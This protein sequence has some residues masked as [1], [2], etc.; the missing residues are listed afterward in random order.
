VRLDDGST[1]ICTVDEGELERIGAPTPPWLPLSLP[2][3][4]EQRILR[5]ISPAIP[6]IKLSGG[7]AMTMTRLTK[8]L[9]IICQMVTT[10]RLFGCIALV[11]IMAMAAIPARANV[12]DPREINLL[13]GSWAVDLDVMYMGGIIGDDPNSTLSYGSTVSPNGWTGLLSGTFFGLPVNVSYTGTT[14]LISS[15]MSTINVVAAGAVGS[16]A[17]T[18][19]SVWNLVDP[20]LKAGIGGVITVGIEGTVG[21]IGLGASVSKDIVR[22]KLSAD[23]TAGLLSVPKLGALVNVGLDFNLDQNTGIDDSGLTI[24]AFW[25]LLEHRT[26]LDETSLFT[27]PTPPP[28]LPPP[29]PPRLP[30]PPYIPSPEEFPGSTGGFSSSDPNLPGTEYMYVGEVAIPEPSTLALV[31]SGLLGLALMGRRS[32]GI[33]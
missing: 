16:N 3:K 18:D 33:Y 8:T 1:A 9:A 13:I 12:I 21:T 15:T 5:Q 7:Q 22:K 32:R 4:P 31:L 30:T 26:V 14:T 19:T 20:E 10:G 23:V 17:F 11:A 29:P 28:H 2:T 24:S 27:S 25:G 6:G